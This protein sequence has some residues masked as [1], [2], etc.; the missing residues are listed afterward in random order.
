MNPH[1]HRIRLAAVHHFMPS[2][3]RGIN[4]DSQYGPKPESKTKWL[5]KAT[6]G[7]PILVVL[8]A[9]LSL[10]AC[11]DSALRIAAISIQV[12]NVSSDIIKAEVAANATSIDPAEAAKL[13]ALADK[14]K[15]AAA[16]AQ[17]LTNNYQQFPAGSK[18]PL[19]AVIT[20]LVAA[21]QEALDSGL[22]GIKNPVVQARIRVILVGVQAALAVAS[23]ELGGN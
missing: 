19:R 16:L 4:Q 8:L 23:S 20:P 12:A 18:P 22:T 3:L 6:G 15:A 21:F 1:T 14:L 5:P 10:A 13:N 7:L 11:K 17:T 9:C 2:T